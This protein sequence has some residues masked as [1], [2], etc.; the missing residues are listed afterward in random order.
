MLKN[1]KNKYILYTL[2]S[3]SL[4]SVVSVGFSSWIINNS[5]GDTTEN[6]N[7]T[8]GEV[9][10]NTISANITSSDVSVS[11]DA[12]EADLCTNEITNGDG[13]VEDLNYG[14]RTQ[15]VSFDLNSDG[16]Y[17]YVYLG[18]NPIGENGKNVYTINNLN[19]SEILNKSVYGDSIIVAISSSSDIIPGFTSNIGDVYQKTGDSTYKY[20]GNIR[21]PQGDVALTYNKELKMTSSPG[22]TTSYNNLNTEDFNR[23]P[24]SGEY[25][26]VYGYGLDGYTSVEGKSYNLLCAVTNTNSDYTSL[27]IIQYFETTGKQGPKGDIGNTG[28]KGDQ[29]IQGPSGI[30]LSLQTGLYSSPADLPSFSSVPLFN[31]YRVQNT[32]GVVVTTDLYFKT[33]GAT[34]WDIQENWGGIP[35]PEG[36]AGPQGPKGDDGNT[37]PAGPQ[38]E[39]GDPGPNR[40]IKHSIW[41]HL[42]NNGGGGTTRIYY[43]IYNFSTSPITLSD[44]MSY[45]NNKRIEANG[46]LRTSA[47]NVGAVCLIYAPGGTLTVESYLFVD[48]YSKYY[49][50]FTITDVNDQVETIELNTA[51]SIS[52]FS[53][54]NTEKSNVKYYK[55]GVEVTFNEY[56][57]D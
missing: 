47:G 9:I 12:L 29:G 38:G 24:V 13:N 8:F 41:S 39:Q 5:K 56:N 23:Q 48:G 44:V 31:A 2:I 22:I 19:S 55:N 46:S 17:N 15:Y 49:T 50:D 25:V 32:S 26:N 7:I 28:P 30:T 11:F 20:I 6:F 10:D 53:L 3:L 16:V 52:L 34:T 14:A 36:P 21:G 37:G 43:T 54:N 57:N 1:K 35:G 33:E 18:A 42:S 4:I 51:N 45:L 27:K 40:I